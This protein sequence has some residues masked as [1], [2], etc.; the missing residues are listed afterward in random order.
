MNSGEYLRYLRKKSRHATFAAMARSGLDSGIFISAEA[1]RKYETGVIPTQ[2]ARAAL[3]TILHMDDQEILLL[4]YLCA[5]G[6]LAKKYNNLDLFL[7]CPY[8]REQV[9]NDIAR[10][11]NLQD[12]S[13]EACI[14]E[15]IKKRA[16]EV[17]CMPKM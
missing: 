15:A 13:D 6:D 1:I 17:L 9:A 2:K 16:E 3:V 8:T 14:R 11:V 10:G 12:L 5:R 4:E 7:V